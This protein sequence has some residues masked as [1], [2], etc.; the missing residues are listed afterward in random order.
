[1]FLYVLY[2]CI[3]NY[4]IEIKCYN[5][6]IYLKYVG[7]GKL[8]DDFLVFLILFFFCFIGFK[9]LLIKEYVFLICYI[10]YN[11]CCY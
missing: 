7:Y 5:N 6:K 8:I 2:E 3:D 10:I 11:C 9:F 4:F 1:M